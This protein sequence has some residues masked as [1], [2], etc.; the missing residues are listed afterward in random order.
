[1]RSFRK[2]QLLLGLLSLFVFSCGP[3]QIEEPLNF[4]EEINHSSGDGNQENG[5]SDGNSDVGDGD[6]DGGD[7]GDDSNGDGDGN[8]GNGDSDGNDGD[9]DGDG[10]GDSV[11]ARNPSTML[12]LN[13][14]MARET[15]DRIHPEVVEL[16]GRLVS[17]G[18]SS[19]DAFFLEENVPE[20][21]GSENR[22]RIWT[23]ELIAQW[24]AF[25]VENDIELVP[26]VNMYEP[27]EDQIAGW[28]KF[29][30]QGVRINDI[31]FGGEYYLRQWFEGNPSNGVNGQIRIDRSLDDQFPPEEDA[32]YYL[33]MLDEFLPAFR[34]AFP[35]RNLYITSCSTREGGGQFQAYRRYWRQRIFEY[36]EENADLVDGFRFHIYVGSDEGDQGNEEQVERLERMVDLIDEFPLPVYVAE[37]GRQDATW[38]SEGMAR[39]EDFVVTIGTALRGRNDES[40]QGFHVDYTVWNPAGRPLGHPYAFTTTQDVMAFYYPDDFEAG[41]DAVA[42]TKIGA[43]FVENWTTLFD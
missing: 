6:D 2:L 25:F 12:S 23:E 5:D 35:G 38:D 15:P 39:L 7:D 30:D 19:Q 9:G 37:S 32:R 41:S 21:W 43:W 40:I 11:S 27:L 28:Q 10:D 1:M 36:A 42:L 31:L 17:S 29:V 13:S 20:G 33:E 22:T 3:T 34:D 24:S 26:S 16:L 14:R 8:D 4:E 18:N